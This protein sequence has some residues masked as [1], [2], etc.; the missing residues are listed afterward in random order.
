VCVGVGISLAAVFAGYC[1][2]WYMC[3][4]CLDIS[5]MLMFANVAAV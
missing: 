1:G 2:T 3:R 5:A 4:Q